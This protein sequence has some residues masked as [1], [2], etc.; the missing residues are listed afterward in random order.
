MKNKIIYTLL[1]I[2][3]AAGILESCGKKDNKSDDP[4]SKLQFNQKSSVS[5]TRPCGIAISKSGIVAVVQYN[6]FINYGSNGTTSIWKTYADFAANKAP[7]Q[8][9]IS[10][11]AEAVCFDTSD[12]LYIAETEKTAGIVIYKKLAQGDA[13]TYSRAVTIFSKVAGGFYN[14]RGIAVDSQGRLFIAN[15]G[16]GNIVRVSDPL[17][18]GA[19]QI[20]A[21]DME[22]IKG[23][24][25]IGSKMYTTMYNQD[26]V[27]TCTLKANG[28]FG[29]LTNSFSV[30]KPVDIAVK[31][32]VLAISSPLGTLTL[33]NP[34]EIHVGAKA[35]SGCK[36]EI[37]VGTNLFGLAFNPAGTE[38]V[39]AN[40]DQNKVIVYQP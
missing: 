4:C 36:K 19:Q 18:N 38:L 27:Y 29:E 12:N 11:G 15:D 8:T 31:D 7:L 16:E 5:Y 2:V 22:S 13:F 3:T 26:A 14:P 10:V 35:Y 34:D 24:A 1:L 6:G 33:I 39:A 30:K 37:T 28:D 32:G 20:I 17:N 21:A 9:F 23:I 40:L 25:I